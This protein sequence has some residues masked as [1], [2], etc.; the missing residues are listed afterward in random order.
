ML[1]QSAI[2]VIHLELIDT[3][4]AVVKKFIILLFRVPARQQQ[5]PKR[6]FTTFNIYPFAQSVLI[7]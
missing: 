6:P 3:F 4:E 1:P 5:L 7:L 2:S